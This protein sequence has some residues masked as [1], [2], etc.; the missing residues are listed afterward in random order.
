MKF[1][2]PTSKSG[3]E[4]GYLESFSALEPTVDNMPREFLRYQWSFL[5]VPL[6]KMSPFKTKF[7]RTVQRNPLFGKEDAQDARWDSS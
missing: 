6:N 5:K 4:E 7:Y 1:A 3:D 2:D